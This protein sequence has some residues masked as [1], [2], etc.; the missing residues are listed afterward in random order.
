M[1]LANVVADDVA[2]DDGAAVDDAV[3]A[4]I[5]QQT[6][7]AVAVVTSWGSAH[8]DGD[9]AAVTA[10]AVTSAIRTTPRT[11]TPSASVAVDAGDV[12]A[13]AVVAAASTPTLVSSGYPEASFLRRSH[14]SDIPS[15]LICRVC[16]V[17]KDPTSSVALDGAAGVG[18]AQVV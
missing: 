13:A 15:Y 2:G 12:A 16:T 18:K 5:L 14:A 9:A 3:V 6:L 8:G 4:P 11:V 1:R 17:D 10:V 7:A